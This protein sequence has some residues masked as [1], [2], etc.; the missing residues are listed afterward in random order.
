MRA[1]HARGLM[2]AAKCAA[3]FTAKFHKKTLA[4]QE[5]LLGLKRIY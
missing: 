5:E 2:I 3:K 4:D 1:I